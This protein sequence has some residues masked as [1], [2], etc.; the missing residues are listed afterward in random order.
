MLSD[1]SCDCGI[2]KN[3]GVWDRVF[4]I[5]GGASI[6]ALAFVGPTTPWAYL[7]LIPLLTGVIGICPAYCSLGMSTCRVRPSKG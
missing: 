4:R 1:Q 5:V 3:L 7:G 6:L 2:P